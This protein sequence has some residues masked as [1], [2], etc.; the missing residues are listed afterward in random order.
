M[1]R[2]MALL[3]SLGFHRPDPDEVWNK[4]WYFTRCERCGSDLVR[5]GSG[6]WH[7]PKGR[8]VVWKSKNPRG[9]K[10]GQGAEQ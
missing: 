1:P 9:R 10:P 7:V 8:K 6:K 2:S 5:T 3:C 4:G